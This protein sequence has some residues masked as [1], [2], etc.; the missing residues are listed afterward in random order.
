MR[1]VEFLTAARRTLWPGEY[2]K[3]CESWPR[4]RG[5]LV[6]RP[7]ARRGSLGAGGFREVARAVVELEALLLERR[8]YHLDLDLTVRAIPG[9]I[10]RRIGHQILLAK[11][12]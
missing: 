9:F 7:F 4:L 5:L 10:R 11:V 3:F 1:L 2:N 12:F 8:I 6:L